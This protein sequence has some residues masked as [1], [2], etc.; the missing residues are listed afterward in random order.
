MPKRFNNDEICD[1]EIFGHHEVWSHLP[2]GQGLADYVG[3]TADEFEAFKSRHRVA[4]DAPMTYA[5]SM[6]F[7]FVIADDACRSLYEAIKRADD[8]LCDLYV[9]HPLFEGREHLLSVVHQLRDA[10]ESH[11]W[12]GGR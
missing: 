9:E 7:M 1:G 2:D 11:D 5:D 3:I 6:A 4:T 10:A 12:A 8:E